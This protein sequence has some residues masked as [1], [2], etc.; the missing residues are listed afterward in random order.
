MAWKPAAFAATAA[1]AR[2]GGLLAS[3]NRTL[4]GRP[5]LLLHGG[6]VPV[7]LARPNGKGSGRAAA[8]ICVTVRSLPL[9]M[10][11]INCSPIY[12]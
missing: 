5:A 11:V 7:D 9:S 4:T 2:A 10:I 6:M 1:C 12:N 3:P 8:T